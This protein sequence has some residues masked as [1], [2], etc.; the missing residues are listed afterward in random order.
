MRRSNP[1]SHFPDEA[2]FFRSPALPGAELLTARF[3]QHAYAPHWHECY[4]V[5]IITAGAEGYRYC[6]ERHVAGPL[7][8][9]CINP[10]EV[11]T[12]ERAADEGWAY[13]VFYP[14]PEMLAGLLAEMNGREPAG[15]PAESARLPR[16]PQQVVRDEPL[17]RALLHAHLL[18]ERGEDTLEAQTA[19]LSAFSALLR[20]HAEAALDATPANHAAAHVEA[21][22]QLLAA[23]ISEPLT[24]DELAAAVGLSP[25]H[26][27]RLFT[28]ETGL[29]PH[30]WRNALR[31]N[32]SLAL[33]RQGES[34]AD[35]AAALGF[36]D[37]SHYTRHFRRVFGVAPGRWR[38]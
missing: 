17:A 4:V 12:G 33:L 7:S 22:R 2:R 34:V 1:Q 29:P 18:L 37:Q 28:R 16:L 10:G 35:T 30:A 6:G 26:A 8:L 19:A 5:A 20:R 36:S 38:S 11:H 25:F 27:A 14:R 13:R 32:R 3:F 21:M 24:L 15:S 31:V 9:A 23:N